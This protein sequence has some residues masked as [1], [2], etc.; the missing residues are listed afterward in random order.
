MK[1]ILR[2]QIALGA[3][4]LIGTFFQ[5]R[6]FLAHLH[7]KPMREFIVYFPLGAFII[8]IPFVL[9]VAGSI[10]LQG[11][12]WGLVVSCI[13]QFLVCLAASF[14]FFPS[15]DIFVHHDS[16][17]WQTLFFICSAPVFFISLS[18]FVLILIR[19]LRKDK[20]AYPS[21]GGNAA[22]PRASA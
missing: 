6:I 12:R 17:G 11:K 22:P 4:L 9:M 20:L 16:G 18:G 15:L 7:S 8:L 5:T 14:V 21:A 19:L 13:S 3:V 2:L 10:A 1:L